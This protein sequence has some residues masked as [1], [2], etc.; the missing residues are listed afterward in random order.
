MTGVEEVTDVSKLRI[1]NDEDEQKR[2]MR[3]QE[4]R[5]KRRRSSHKL[6]DNSKP[7]LDGLKKEKKRKSYLPPSLEILNKE[8][9]KNSRFSDL[10]DLALF[11]LEANGFPSPTIAKVNN[12][13]LIGRVVFLI[14]PGLELADFGIPEDTEKITSCEL[15]TI[16]EQLTFFKQHFDKFLMVYSPG[17]RNSLYPLIKAFTSVPYTKKQKNKKVKELESKTL[18]L[19]DLL[20]S[21][22]DFL[23]NDYPVHP[24]VLN[25][26]QEQIKPITEGWVDTTQFEHEGSHTFSLDCEMCQTAT[27]KVLTRISLINFDEETLLDEFVKPED[28]IVDYLTQYSGITEELLKNVT[29]SLKDIQDK[30]CK[31]ISADDILIGHSIENDLNVLKIRHPRIIDTS[32][33]F[34]H[35]RGPPFK[36][37]LKYLAK[38]Y[39]DKTIQNGSHDSVEDAKTCLELVKLKLVNNALLGKVIDGESLFKIL[40]DSGRKAVVLDNLKIQNDHKKYLACSNDDEVVDSILEKAADTDL[41]VAKFKDLESSLGWD[42]I[43]ST[44]ELEEKQSTYTDKTQAFEDLNNRL[45]KIYKGLPGNT[46]IILTSGY[47]NPCKVK[48]LGIQKRNFKNDYQNKLYSEI[49]ASWDSEDEAN[50]KKSLKIARMGVGFMT[51]KSA[52]DSIISSLQADTKSNGSSILENDEEAILEEDSEKQ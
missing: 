24:L 26:P 32:L 14:I 43:P 5:N 25:V 44:Q 20:M 16:P 6:H 31:I 36:S 28:E 9:D 45:E 52:D 10:R 35:P 15:T 47:S 40:G 50:L 30:I 22:E 8:T 34:E 42:K 1:S 2:I 38:Q 37:S 51:L 48:S 3:K 18:V 27:G 12:R 19:P 23:E 33:I 21:H 17:D 41:I 7:K 4:H 39:L 49:E 11:I 46:A 13:H 29:T